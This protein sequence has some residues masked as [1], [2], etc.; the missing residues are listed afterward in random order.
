M[1]FDHGWTRMNT[2]KKD[3]HQSD[4]LIKR[5]TPLEDS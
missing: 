3:S 1:A 4:V 5:K 2:D